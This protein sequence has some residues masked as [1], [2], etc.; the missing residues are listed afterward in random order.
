MSDDQK[1]KEYAKLLGS[2]GGKA[3]AKLPKEKLKAI[4]AM[5]HKAKK[6]KRLSTGK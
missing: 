6:E 5:G 2:K 4:S 3:R 1:L